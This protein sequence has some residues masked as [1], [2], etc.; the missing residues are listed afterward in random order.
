VIWSITLSSGWIRGSGFM[1]GIMLHM[2]HAVI[3]STAKAHCARRRWS[4]AQFVLDVPR[5]TSRLSCALPQRASI[6]DSNDALIT[7]PSNRVS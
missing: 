3:P 6:A 2:Q 1:A 4:L 7:S 5:I